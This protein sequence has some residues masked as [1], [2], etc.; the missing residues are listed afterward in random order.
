MRIFQDP[1]EVVREIERDLYEMGTRYVSQTIQDQKVRENTIEL[2]GYGYMLSNWTEEQMQRAICYFP[3]GRWDWAVAEIEE[4]LYK[5]I[6]DAHPNPGQ[7]WKLAEDLWG[8]FL[9]NGVFSY[10]Y[11]ERWQHQL[12]YIIRELKEVPQTRQAIMTMYST[13]RDMM[14]WRGK[15]RVPCSLTYQFLLRERDL[16]LIYNQRSCDFLQFFMH[17]VYFSCRL[18][19]YVAKRVGA[20]TGTFIHMIGSLH[21]FEKDMVERKIF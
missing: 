7:A 11:A 10:S 3:K 4:R 9:R 12:P 18:L 15:D 1:M 20:D 5:T 16:T 14:N 8:P 2:V 21:A 13:E 6:G 19:D 17:D